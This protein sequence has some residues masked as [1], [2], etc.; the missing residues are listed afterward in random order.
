MLIF[1]VGVPI[2]LFV[3]LYSNRQAIME[4]ETRS[5]DERLDSIAFLFRLYHQSYW[6]L[7]VIGES[8]GGV[9]GMAHY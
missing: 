4:R 8:G 2:I 3:L 7:P 1:P 5:G 6:Y 9:S